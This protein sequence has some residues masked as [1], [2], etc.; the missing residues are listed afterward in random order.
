MF[1]HSLPR[2]RSTI[3]ASVDE[4]SVVSSKPSSND[5]ESSECSSEVSLPCSSDSEELSLPST[6]DEET[7]Y[8]C[9]EAQVSVAGNGRNKIPNVDA[10]MFPTQ[11]SDPGEAVLVAECPGGHGAQTTGGVPGDDS[12]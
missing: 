7:L 2:R 12:I 9:V 5:E 6:E 4:G 8:Q 3:S 10:A 11:C 1:R